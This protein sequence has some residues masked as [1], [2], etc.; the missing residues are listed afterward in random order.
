[1]KGLLIVNPYRRILLISPFF[2][3]GLP[4]GGVLYSI[5]VAREWLRR[6]REVAVICGRRERSL[7]D[8]EVFAAAERLTIHPIAE[9]EQLR[10]T[11]HPDASVASS[12]RRVIETFEP[13]VIHAH[14]LH[15]HLS[16]IDAAIASPAPV[17]LTALDFGLLCFN[18]YLFDGTT[19][20]CA[21]PESASRCAA[22]VGR[23]IRGPAAWLGPLLPRPVTRRLWPRFVRL[24][25]MKQAAVLH[26][27]M[28]RILLGCDRIVA[29]SP[30]MAERL[31]A[32]GAREE[33]VIELVY[34]VQ[35][36][37]IVRPPK[38]PSDRVRLAFMGNAGQ[39]KG[40]TVLLEAVD[41]LPDGLPLEI[42][43]YGGEEVEAAVENASPGAR[44]YLS[45]HLPVFG[46]SLAEEQASIDAVLVPS[47]WHEN[48][49]FVVLESL[50]NG[51]PVLASDQAGIRHLIEHEVNGLLI[52]AGDA[53]A[54]SEVLVDAAR[55]PGRIRAMA[56]RATF[57]RTTTDFID[58]LE[59]VEA[60][61]ISPPTRGATHAN[62]DAPMLATVRAL[63]Q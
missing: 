4:S 36:D 13:D 44:R 40:L 43:A 42:R 25:Q 58:D 16:A 50:A 20:P 62:D 60:E 55:E 37:K 7:G 53:G 45:W 39:V 35:P 27:H 18:F 8:L 9:P 29:P 57:T 34:G 59:S 41:R 51:T 6:G 30:I 31:R 56:A 15:G 10:F 14:N 52:P 11:H 2:D 17:I 3:A 23:T 48:A 5:D 47:L 19:A 12:A 1:M 32:Y 28:R 26:G 22:C 63:S 54:W 24:D 21:G 46:H 33:Q 61:L 38:H 49:P